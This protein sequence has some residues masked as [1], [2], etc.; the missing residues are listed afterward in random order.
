M[1]KYNNINYHAVH[2][3]VAS[4]ILRVGKEYGQTSISYLLRKLVINQK[5]W[6]LCYYIML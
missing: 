1:R 4:G 3:S 6:D 2:K 5:R